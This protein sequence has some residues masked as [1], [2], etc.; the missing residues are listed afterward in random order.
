VSRQD[1]FITLYKRHRLEEQLSWSRARARM[2]IGQR[3]RLV[4]MASGLLILSALSNT[5]AAR[6]IG[7][8]NLLLALGI[9][10]PVSSLALVA[11]LGFSG[12]GRQAKLYLD[13]ADALE[14]A[15]AEGESLR[16]NNGPGEVELA[17]WV[18]RIES[19]LQAGQAQASPMSSI[20]PRP[21]AGH[22]R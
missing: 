3:R 5:L 2:L 18:E 4:T 8:V 7:P 17:D 20:P 1:D 15:R 13:V 11:V 16:L 14:T 19:I 12:V 21:R 22:E 9:I 6:S 10:F